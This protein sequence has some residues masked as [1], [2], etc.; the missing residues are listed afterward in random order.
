M[1]RSAFVRYALHPLLGCLLVGCASTGPGD[2]EPTDAGLEASTTVDAAPPVD[3][4]TSDA[5]SSSDGEADAVPPADA[6]GSDVV[7]FPVED[8]GAPGVCGVPGGTTATASATGGSNVASN[9]IDGKST[10]Y[11]GSGGTGGTL[12]LAFPKATRF[13]RARVLVRGV[14]GTPSVTFSFAGRTAKGATAIGTTKGTA[15]ATGVWLPEAALTA[16]T[17]DGLDVAMTASTACLVA[18]V[19]VYDS[20]ATCT[21][22]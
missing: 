14:F 10:T 4:S 13:D 9:A 21:P 18:E 22:P 16:G 19:F 3:A 15:T 12:R 7:I 5:G 20:T 8:V 2:A 1:L 17:W 11:W 6:P